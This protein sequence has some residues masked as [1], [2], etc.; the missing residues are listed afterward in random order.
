MANMDYCKFENTFSDLTDCWNGWDDCESN[1][2]EKYRKKIL[3]LCI[4]IAVE[5]GGLEETE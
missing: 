4:K 5:I 2:E 3:A 1:R